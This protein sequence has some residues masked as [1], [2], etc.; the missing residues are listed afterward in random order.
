VHLLSPNGEIYCNRSIGYPN[1]NALFRGD[2]SSLALQ[3]VGE[4]LRLNNI[5]PEQVVDDEPPPYNAM[6]QQ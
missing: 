3:L 2:L 4:A 1:G 5:M 6:A